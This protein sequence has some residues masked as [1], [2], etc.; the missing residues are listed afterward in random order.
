MG[1]HDATNPQ[2]GGETPRGAQNRDRR[3][4]SAH[5][6]TVGRGDRGRVCDTNRTLCGG[7]RAVRTLGMASEIIALLNDRALLYLEAPVKRVTGFDVVTPYFGREEHYL[8]SVGLIRAGMEE[9]LD[10]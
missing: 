5:D 8:P 3:D 4:R 7:P 10:F 1:S 9:T 6:G 2:S